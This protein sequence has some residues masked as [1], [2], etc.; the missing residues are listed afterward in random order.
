MNKVAKVF[1]VTSNLSSATDTREESMANLAKYI[2]ETCQAK[3]LSVD[4]L[5]L[6]E[7]IPD[8]F[9][10]ATSEKDSIIIEYQIRFQRADLV[11]FIYPIKLGHVPSKIKYFVESV[12]SRGFAYKIIKGQ[13]HGNFTDKSIWSVAITDLPS[14]KV[15]TIWGNGHTNWWKRVV[16]EY[17]GSEIKNWVIPNWRSIPEE[18]IMSWKEYFAKLISNL[19]SNQNLLDLI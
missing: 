9:F 12:F 17:S 16:K 18:K 10:H 14:W 1:I 3:E 19:N 7:G 4:L 8:N 2:L 15:N 13:I 11:I 5:N 6:D